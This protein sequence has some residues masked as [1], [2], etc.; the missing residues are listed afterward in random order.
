MPLG[1]AL[2]E[3]AGELLLPGDPAFED[4]RRVQNDIVDRRPALIARCAGVADVMSA[5]TFARQHGLRVAVRSGGH[6]FPG[7]SM[8]DDAFVIDLSPMKGVRVDPQERTARV[9]AGVLLGELDRETQ[10]FGLA[11]PSGIVTH[12]GVAGLTLGGGIGWIMRKYGLSVDMLRRVDLVT[13]DGELVKA[14]AD[15]NED[16]FW[17]VRGAGANFGIATEFEFDLASVGPTILA[18]PIFWKMEDSPEVLRFYRDWAGNAPDELMSIVIHRKAP[19]LPFVPEELHGQPVVMVI[20]CWVGDLEEGEKFIKPMRE[21][22]N[23][24]ADVCTQKPFLAHQSMFDPSFVPGR[25][26]YFRAFD[27]PELTDEM[28]DITVDYSLRIKS[29]LTSFP[30]WQMGGAV[31]RVGEDETAFGGRQAAFTYNIGC[32]TENAEGFAEEREWVRDFYS[33]LEEWQTSVYVNFLSGEEEGEA[34]VRAAYGEVKYDR[35]KALKRKWDPDNFFR[36]N[37][38]VSPD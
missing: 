37:Q 21:F 36:I 34:R 1:Q 17:G 8:A 15:E 19:P 12:T 25:W 22:G 10:A 9:Q 14:S 31:A 23:A 35:L 20:P 6:S 11:A 28:I 26:Y 3:F 38:N 7:L 18:G 27:V 30:I 16:L 2:P 24:V 33:A 32:S 4:A 13:A 5:V 29:P